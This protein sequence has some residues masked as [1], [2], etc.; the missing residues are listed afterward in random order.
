MQAEV[1]LLSFVDTVIVLITS[2]YE[3]P[4]VEQKLPNPRIKPA[5]AFIGK[6]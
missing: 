3:T 4:Q 2:I 1:K 5:S 6:G